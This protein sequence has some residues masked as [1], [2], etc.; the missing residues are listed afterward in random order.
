MRTASCIILGAL[1][2]L[3]GC[4]S[5]VGGTHPA[6]NA[7]HPRAEA[8]LQKDAPRQTSRESGREASRT[9]NREAGKDT[10]R[11]AGSTLREAIRLYT[12]GDFAGAI[13]KLEAPDLQ[14]ANLATRIAAL[15]YTAFSY[16]VTQ[17]PAPCRQ[18]FD[19]ALRLDA[20]FALAPG[21][22]GHPM[23]GPVYDKARAARQPVNAD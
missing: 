16:C 19:K 7:D 21:E 18:A 2:L 1:M 5:S 6:A 13:A 9:T 15:K 10:G 17:R 23:W 14:A 4:A 8:Y 20:N 12:N 22:E 3:D 11:D